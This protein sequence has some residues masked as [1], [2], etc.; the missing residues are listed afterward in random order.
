MNRQKSGQ[1]TGGQFAERDR[2]EADVSLLGRSYPALII[3]TPDQ[4][5]RG[6]EASARAAAWADASGQTDPRTS[7][8]Y[9]RELAEQEAAYEAFKRG[10]THPDDDA[11]DLMWKVTGRE[12]HERELRVAWR[13]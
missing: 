13:H 6:R 11:F 4:E 3:P 1:P 2:A 8:D 5:R 10:E 9:A 12:S 7:E